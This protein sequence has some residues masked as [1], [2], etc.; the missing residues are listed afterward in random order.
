MYVQKLLRYC[1]SKTLNRNKEPLITVI[2][3]VNKRSSVFFFSVSLLRETHHR[4]IIILFSERRDTDRLVVPCH[5]LALTKDRVAETSRCV[6][7]SILVYL[8]G[9][10]TMTPAGNDVSE[11][12]AR[13][14]FHEDNTTTAV[15][16]GKC[17]C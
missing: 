16:G 7:K 8:T 2:F 12:D 1:V 3:L 15:M 17:R 9:G 13:R 14:E 11:G 10:A 4:K 6:Y 5:E